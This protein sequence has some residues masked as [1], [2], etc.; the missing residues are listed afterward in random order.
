MLAAYPA[1]DFASPIAAYTALMTDAA[2]ACQSDQLADTAA[3]HQ[4]AP[5]YRFVFDHTY[6]GALA[7]FGA[8]HGMDLYMV[9]RNL[10]RYIAFDAGERALSDQL[11]A[12]WSTFAHTGAL[13]WPRR[14]DHG[15]Q[16]ELL[17][18]ALHAGTA[19]SERC[20]KWRSLLE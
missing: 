13:A 8:G 6:A 18:R 5:V 9:F 4:T 11:I 14:A 2:F 19:S 15:A 7:R 1:S 17:D 20:A 12:A 10:P 16:V 3:V